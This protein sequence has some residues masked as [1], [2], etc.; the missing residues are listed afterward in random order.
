MSTRQRFA[1][2]GL[3]DYLLVRDQ[4]ICRTP[5]CDAP[6]RQIDH[7]TPHCAEGE[8]TRDNTQGLC[9]ACNLAEQ[10][11]GWAQSVVPDDVSRH[12]VETVTPTGHRHLSRAPAPPCP[13]RPSRAR[14]CTVVV[15][16]HKPAVRIALSDAFAAA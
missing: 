15:E 7:V 14:P 6:A 9:Q 5:W 16:L 4:G 13:A 2:Q 3:V 1:T 11:T 8:T 10:A 12:T